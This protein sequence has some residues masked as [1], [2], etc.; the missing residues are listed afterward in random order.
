MTCPESNEDGFIEGIEPAVPF[1][2]H[3]VYE[4]PGSV[5][6]VACAKCRSTHLEVGL[7]SY[8]VVVRCPTCKH[9]SCLFNG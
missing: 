2:L 4:E 3:Q 8:Y 5:K 7:G 9:E 6:L 1:R